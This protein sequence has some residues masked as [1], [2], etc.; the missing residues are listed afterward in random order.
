[1]PV[2]CKKPKFAFRSDV[3]LTFCNNKVIEAKLK[4]V[5]LAENKL[6]SKIYKDKGGKYFI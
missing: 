6:K 4:K 5:I 1:M 3:R 2:P